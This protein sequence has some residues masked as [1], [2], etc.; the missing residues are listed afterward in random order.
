MWHGSTKPFYVIVEIGTACDFGMMDA[1]VSSLRDRY[2][3][4]FISSG[5]R[6]VANADI[7]VEYQI[8][9]AVIKQPDEATAMLGM[10]VVHKLWHVLSH[11]FT[12]GVGFYVDYMRMSST[13][14][15]LI[16]DTVAKYKPEGVLAHCGVAMQLLASRVF[17]TYPSALVYFAPGFL[18]NHQIPFAFDA[19]IK[20]DNVN[21]YDANPAFDYTASGFLYQ[22]EIKYL[23]GIGNRDYHYLSLIHHINAFAPPLVPDVTYSDKLPSLRVTSL[24]MLRPRTPPG[25]SKKLPETLRQWVGTRKR[26]PIIFVTFGS[27][28]HLLSQTFITTLIRSLIKYAARKKLRVLVRA[29]S[30]RVLDE[31]PELHDRRPRGVCYVT[32]DYVP[33]RA[34]VQYCELVCFTGSVCL[35]NEC[36]YQKCNMLFVPLLSEQYLWA[37]LYR[38]HTGVPFIDHLTY[39]FGTVRDTIL[40]AHAYSDPEFFEVVQQSFSNDLFR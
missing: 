2:T 23:A 13:L 17:T 34:L 35:Q 22:D 14:T 18:P 10:G 11:L 19:R 26:P 29:P 3:L 40:A 8:P 39:D 4:V 38:H 32:H 6:V 9:E 27:F 7:K 33:Y 20:D 25:I 28:D 5:T 21:I 31:V 16:K 30:T 24:G 37:K 1:V 15:R 12:T 36:W